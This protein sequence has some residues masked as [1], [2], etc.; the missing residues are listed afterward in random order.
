M[1][2]IFFVPGMFGSTVEFCIRNFTNEYSLFVPE[3][4]DSYILNDGS[5][6]SFKKQYHLTSTE[7]YKQLADTS[8]DPA[9]I[10]TPIYPTVDSHFPELL[11][12]LKT[13]K[14][15]VQSKNILLH[16][17]DNCSG[18]LNLFFQY[19]KIAI[20][21]DLGL[22]IFFPLGKSL[23]QWNSEYSCWT[24]LEHWELRE[25]FSIFYPEWV[26]EWADS[27]QHADDNFL[28][29]S[30]EDFLYNTK[31]ELYKIFDY[32]GLT[33]NK[34][35][36]DNFI[37]IWQNKQE[38]IIKQRDL[39]VDIVNNTLNNKQQSWSRL[40]F[41]QEAVVQRRLRDAGYE[42]K[43]WKLNEFPTETETLYNLL[44]KT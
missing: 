6:H 44:E 13:S 17:K 37:K 22:D 42:L 14:S 5:M 35:D 32:C 2:N 20:G 1:I 30:N 26:E 40:N 24:D 33:P 11:E 7:L 9:S 8:Q 31:E 27:K 15:F 16:S 36:L 23:A 21:L 3:S 28:A 34:N 39:C 12:I 38:Y 18:E 4:L 25:W 19:E 41:V 43:C 10:T 29:V